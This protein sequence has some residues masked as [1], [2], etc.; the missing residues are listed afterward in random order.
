M[1]HMIAAA[2]LMAVSSGAALAGGTHAGGHGDKPA[3]MAIGNPG[4]AKQAK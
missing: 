3:T 4:K 1:K 2:V